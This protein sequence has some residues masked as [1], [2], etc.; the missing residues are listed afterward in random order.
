MT[1]TFVRRGD[2]PSTRRSE[3]TLKAPNGGYVTVSV[4]DHIRTMDDSRSIFVYG[5]VRV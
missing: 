3:D 1:R 2:E 5:Y 4:A